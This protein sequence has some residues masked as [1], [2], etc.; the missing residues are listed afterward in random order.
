MIKTTENCLLNDH[1]FTQNSLWNAITKIS[2]LQ[3]FHKINSSTLI[4]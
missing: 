1:N 2:P 4:Q 3:Y